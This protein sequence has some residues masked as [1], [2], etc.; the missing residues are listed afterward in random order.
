[1]EP[2]YHNRVELS[3]RL[4]SHLETNILD[5]WMR[6]GPDSKYGGFVTQLDRRGNWYGD[7]Q[8][9]LVP[10]A[11]IVWTFSAAHRARLRDDNYYLDTA[12]SVLRFMM[13]Y[14]WDSTY[15]GWYWS[16]ARD[17][18]PLMTYKDAY[19]LAFAIYALS[20][21]HLATGNKD[22]LDLARKTFD[23][24]DRNAHDTEHGGYYTRFSR[25]WTKPSVAESPTH[26]TWS[27]RDSRHRSV[28]THLHLLEAFTTLF[29]ATGDARHRERL[30]E[31][32]DLVV[33]KLFQTSF[34]CTIENRLAPDWNPVDPDGSL[35][36]CYGHNVE[37]AWVLM[38]AIDAL[39]VPKKKYLDCAQ[40]MV[41]HALRFGWDEEH[42]GL[43]F[44]GP[45]SGPAANR[46]KHEWVQAEAM[47]ALA[48]I[49]KLTA[50][51]RYRQRLTE[52]AGW[53]LEFQADS[54]F[55]EW[56]EVCAEDGT[57][58][59]TQKGC[60][61]RSCYHNGRSCLYTSELLQAGIL[62]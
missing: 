47:I 11:R 28:G 45:L 20:E 54:K 12:S 8:K 19:G 5:F 21:Y 14:L 3:E 25:D 41:D 38:Y 6:H 22:A 31:L 53:C 40:A 34:G 4:R 16:V 55:G 49:Y 62:T 15:G 58:I 33:E 46:N 44:S 32:A 30:Q 39:G 36:T 56:Y 17:G 24:F 59:Q 10:Q 60:V 50:E 9:S 43:Y 13:K 1:M 48:L 27:Q 2:D 29:I 18:K 51:K 35:F 52:L 26:N 37:T 57:P 7:R 61:W 42:S 23:L